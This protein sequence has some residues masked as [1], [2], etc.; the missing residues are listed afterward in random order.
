MSRNFE[1][2]QQLEWEQDRPT[3]GHSKVDPVAGE[4]KA[5]PACNL[6]WAGDEAVELAHRLFLLQKPEP[7]Q[8][9]VFAGIDHNSGCSH[10][11][12][13]VAEALACNTRGLVCL[14][15]ANFRSPG[16]PSLFNTANHYGFTDALLGEGPI[17]S[18]TKSVG[19][20][21]LRLISAGAL[22]A[23]SSNLLTTRL[24]GPRLA[25]LR[26]DFDFVIIDAPP[27]TRYADAIALAQLT[28]GMVL[29]LEA[30]STRR[31]TAMQEV[32]K[33]RSSNISI[34]GAVLNK[35]ICPTPK[36]ISKKH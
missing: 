17:G 21:K 20:N 18:F 36:K 30:E 22:G 7:P 6:Q 35:R 32:E 14:L 11:C 13:S 9:A 10:V 28:D 33:L 5:R 24:V 15:E 31:E 12:A 26:A 19:P 23:D 27:L 29:V 34:L 3:F 16:L 4:D 8:I 25:E 2:M 1:L